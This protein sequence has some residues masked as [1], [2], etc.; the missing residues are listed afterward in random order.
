LEQRLLRFL[1]RVSDLLPAAPKQPFDQEA[2]RELSN[3]LQCVLLEVAVQAACPDYLRVRLDEEYQR[4]KEEQSELTWSDLF[5]TSELATLR[6]AMASGGPT[7]EN[8]DEET[9][10]TIE[11]LTT[12]YQ[13]RSNLERERWAHDRLR[14]ARLQW[15]ARW[16]L[17]LLVS[18]MVLLPAAFAL[19]SS[20]NHPQW[21]ENGIL[22]ILVAV[23]GAL[24]G[25]LSGIR[26]LL[27]TPVLRG[28]LERFQSAFRAQLLVGGTLGLISLLLFEVGALPTFQAIRGFPDVAPLAIYAFLAGFSEPFIFGIVQG[29]VGGRNATP[30]DPAQDRGHAQ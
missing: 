28:E 16:L 19:S 29:L 17:Q 3:E 1:D 12:L 23:I 20:S 22:V 15:V 6:N 13:A 5:D 8:A 2:A 14:D 24:G 25:A 21:L 27:G 4:E 11:M 10:R 18:V 26:R 30:S 9:N 7:P